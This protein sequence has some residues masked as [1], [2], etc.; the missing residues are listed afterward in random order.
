[1]LSKV[2]PLIEAHAWVVADLRC[3]LPEPVLPPLFVVARLE[4][5]RNA[6]KLLPQPRQ[7]LRRRGDLAAKVSLFRVFDPPAYRVEVAR[8]A[9]QDQRVD[10]N[11]FEMAYRRLQRYLAVKRHVDVRQDADNAGGFKNIRLPLLSL[12]RWHR[13]ALAG[14][15]CGSLRRWLTTLSALAKLSTYTIAGLLKRDGTVC[16]FH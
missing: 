8:V 11:G 4:D 12:A 7:Q 6:W 3:V 1:V 16:F 14:L 5:D 2:Q 15:A 9:V 13:D 10:A